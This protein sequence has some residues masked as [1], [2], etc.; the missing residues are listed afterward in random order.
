M[1]SIGLKILSN[2]CVVPAKY[3]DGSGL[4]SPLKRF[5]FTHDRQRIFF[6]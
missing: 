3:H 6:F 2:A 5:T 4:E 1:N